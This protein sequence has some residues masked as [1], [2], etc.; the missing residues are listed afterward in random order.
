TLP[1]PQLAYVEVPFLPVGSNC[2]IPAEEDVAGRLHQVLAVDH[3][4]SVVCLLTSPD[5]FLEHG[6]LGLLGLQ[7]QRIAVISAEEEHDPGPGTDASHLYDLASGVDDLE[8]LE[9]VPAIV[10][11]RLAVTAHDR[12]ELVEDF[13]SLAAMEHVVDRCHER[14]VADDAT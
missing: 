6:G 12:S 13:I 2:A 9:K 5:V 14:G 1:V 8:L 7:E 10:L 3:P 11:Q 4:L